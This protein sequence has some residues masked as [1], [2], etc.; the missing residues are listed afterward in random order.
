M[1]ERRS[2]HGSEGGRR[3]IG[4][5]VAVAVGY[6]VAA[7][8]GFRLAF[9]AEQVTTVWAPTGIGIAA[10]VLWGYNL[11]P[12]IWIGAFIANAGSHAPLWTDGI[13]ATGNTL[14]AVRPRGCCGGPPGSTRDSSEC[15]TSWLSW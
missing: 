10:L 12:A 14:E 13:V 5:G 8:L 15:G 2:V 7:Q 6:V 11:W 3:F 4:V 1:V 9:V